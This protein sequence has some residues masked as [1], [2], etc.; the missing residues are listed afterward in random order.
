MSDFLSQLV[1]RSLNSTPTVRPRVRSLF[2][3]APGAIA[4]I[5]GE[6]F[7]AAPTERSSVE[8]FAP[9][10]AVEKPVAIPQELSVRELV[11][12]DAAA[13]NPPSSFSSVL[14]RPVQLQTSDE[15]DTHHGQSRILGSNPAGTDE[16]RMPG[17]LRA[18]RPAREPLPMVTARVEGKPAAES[19]VGLGK[20]RR[21][22]PAPS[23]SAP[24]TQFKPKVATSPRMPSAPLPASRVIHVTIGRV[25]IRAVAPPQGPA[26]PP[27]TTVA[28]QPL[29]EYLKRRHS[30][31]A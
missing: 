12:T 4:P 2:E 19:A 17:A 15:P 5:G 24:T 29:E 30:R 9:S 3:P 22:V 18:A 31:A 6:P 27:P 26:R 10:P 23:S 1:A 20:D 16:Y 21:S 7:E 11:E 14:P 13:G 25:E 8:R 28:P